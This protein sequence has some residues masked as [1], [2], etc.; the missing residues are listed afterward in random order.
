MLWQ[1][2]SCAQMLMQLLKEQGYAVSELSRR[3]RVEEKAAGRN[4]PRFVRTRNGPSVGQTTLIWP[5]W[6]VCSRGMPLP[7]SHA[8]RR[9]PG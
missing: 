2:N 7:V 6:P 9:F 8:L 1:A 5:H 4:A 3:Q